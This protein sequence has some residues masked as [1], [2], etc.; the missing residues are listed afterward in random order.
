MIEAWQSCQGQFDPPQAGTT[1]AHRGVDH[2]PVLLQQNVNAQPWATLCRLAVKDALDRTIAGLFIVLL[3]PLLLLIAVAIRLDS[4]GPALF[5]Q[6][7]HGLN[8]Q[9]FT[10]R[11][12]R[13]MRWSSGSDDGRIQTERGDC[14]VTRMGGW[15]RCTSLDELPQLWNILNG[16]MSLVG[17]RPHPVAMCTEGRLCEDIDPAYAE[18]HRVKP[19]LT[20]LA[21]IN[22]HRGAT[23]TAAQ[24]RARLADDLRYIETWSLLLDIRIILMTP[25]RLVVHRD[26]AF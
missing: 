16:T 17:P 3:A 8:G 21:Q 15:L 1:V 24:L 9:V 6:R 13:T 26:A 14:R 4:S 2:R 25:I 5:V 11:K 19:G 22:G 12:F 7:R 20:G 23:Q 18:R 10:I